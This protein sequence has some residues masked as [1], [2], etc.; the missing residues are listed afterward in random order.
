MKTLLSL[1]LCLALAVPVWAEDIRATVLEVH[2][3]DTLF[4][5][6]DGDCLPVL[7]QRIGL[8][9]NGC[10]TPELKDARP[11]IRA[12]ANEAR[13]YTKGLL[14]VGQAVTIKGVKW[15]KYGGRIDGTLEVNGQDLCRL[16]IDAGLAREYHG[17]GPKPW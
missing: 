16:L 4:V 6:P 10:D 1:I 3:G 11:D 13:D 5:R 8:R 7:F 15:D 12:L 17:Q 14:P 9:L 2:D